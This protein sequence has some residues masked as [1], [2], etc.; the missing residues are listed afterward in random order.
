VTLDVLSVMVK[1]LPPLIGCCS[2]KQMMMM[3]MMMM[4]MM[5]M[6]GLGLVVAARIV[7]R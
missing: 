2:D 6:M 7:G 5:V 4:L 1:L 3:L